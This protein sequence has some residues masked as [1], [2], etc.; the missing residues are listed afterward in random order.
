MEARMEL[1]QK[2]EHGT[3]WPLLFGVLGVLNLADFFYEFNYQAD[4]LL[5]GLG[6]LLAVPM[7]YCAP[8]SFS[9]KPRPQ[10]LKV[11]PWLRG[12]TIVGLCLVAAGFVVE[13]GWV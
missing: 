2:Q 6:F 9:F 8:A 12:M 1:H 7:A 4:D 3:W 11:H 5:Q 13:W 10:K